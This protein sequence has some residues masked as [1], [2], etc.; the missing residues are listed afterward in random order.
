VV[1][2]FLDVDATPKC[3]MTPCKKNKKDRSLDLSL[4]RLFLFFQSLS[5]GEGF[6]EG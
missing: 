1:V 5:F 2:D 4:Q 6:R 3:G